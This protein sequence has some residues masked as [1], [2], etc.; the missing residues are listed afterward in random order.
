MKGFTN[1][2][3]IVD[4][5]KTF[6]MALKGRLEKHGYSSVTHLLSA[7]EG[8]EFVLKNKPDFLLLDHNL[9]GTNGLDAIQLFKILHREMKIAMVTGSK[10]DSIHEKALGLGVDEFFSKNEL[11]NF[12]LRRF[13]DLFRLSNN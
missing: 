9:E 8:Y 12:K 5:D 6:A 7:E 3:L 2:I 11:L 4:D 10:N 1:Q 13:L